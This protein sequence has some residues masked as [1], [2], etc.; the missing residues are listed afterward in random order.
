MGASIPSRDERES[1]TASNS[2]KR[3]IISTSS[4][5]A[6]HRGADSQDAPSAKRLQAQANIKY[7]SITEWLEYC[8]RDE[9]RK[10]GE[11][12]FSQFA[13]FFVENDYK[14]LDEIVG[15]TEDK[16]MAICIGMKAGTAACLVNYVKEDECAVRMG[17]TFTS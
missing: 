17:K 4:H 13:R 10:R 11:R 14:F 1:R 7:P 15:A 3:R 6:E 5:V 16:I 8:D 2:N 12:N 9:I